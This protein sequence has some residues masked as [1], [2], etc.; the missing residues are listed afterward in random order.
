MRLIICLL[1]LCALFVG[2]CGPER[3]TTEITFPGIKITTEK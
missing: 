3:R 1:L 2:G